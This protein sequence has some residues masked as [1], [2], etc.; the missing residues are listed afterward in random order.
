MDKLE[1]LKDLWQSQPQAGVSYSKEDILNMV[2]KK[3]SSIVKWILIISILEFLIPYVLILFTDLETPS[4]VYAEYDLENLTNYYTAVHFVIILGFFY[5]FYK[6]YRSIS[7]DSSV[8]NLLA[9]I[10]RT[11]RTVK[12][13]IYYN[14]V[15]MGILGLHSF[16]VIMNSE[17]FLSKLPENADITIVWVTALFLYAL[18]LFLFWCFYR[19]IYGFFLRKLKRNY[20]ELKKR[21]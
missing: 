9:D 18:V 20:A 3:S 21:D 1:N 13:Y 4:R 11:R 2:R 15:M 17:S 16:Y 5:V 19:L 6:N 12:Y 14:L 10:L 8:K 7:A